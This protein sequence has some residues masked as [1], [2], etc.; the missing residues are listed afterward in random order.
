[1]WRSFWT[2]LIFIHNKNLKDAVKVVKEVSKK[3]IFVFGNAT[4]VSIEGTSST[5]PTRG[6]ASKQSTQFD[7]TKH[8]LT[9]GY[10]I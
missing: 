10:V 6:Q 1:M 5:G 9:F 3:R 7:L 8:L 4:I 2:I